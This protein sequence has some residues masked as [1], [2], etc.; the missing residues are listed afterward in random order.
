MAGFNGFGGGA[1]MQNL[2]KQAQKMQEQMEKDK[3]ELE[4]TIFYANAGGGMVEV[5]MNGKREL[6]KLAIKPEAV[7]PEDVEMLEDLIM[8]AINDAN[9]QVDEKTQEIMPSLPGGMF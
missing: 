3:E 4:A 5:E 2:L 8:A 7:D 6:V 1:N 9:R